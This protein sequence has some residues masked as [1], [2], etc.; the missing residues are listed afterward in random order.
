[1]IKIVH[2]LLFFLL[3][4]SYNCAY[5]DD[6]IP[7]DEIPVLTLT[8]P[9]NILEEVNCFVIQGN[10]S[11]DRILSSDISISLTLTNYSSVVV[12][13]TVE[14]PFGLTSSL[15]NMP[16]FYSHSEINGETNYSIEIFA[17]YKEFAFDKKDI[18]FSASDLPSPNEI[19]ALI[20]LY[21]CT[22]GE[23]WFD[24]SG[25]LGNPGIEWYG[26]WYGDILLNSI[27]YMQFVES[28]DL[29]D[30]IKIRCC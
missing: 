4:V 27:P 30:N 16:V 3:F 9:E 23:D 6:Q 19:S 11:I 8:L 18:Q 2:Y 28:I 26:L 17:S 13:S 14:I 22:G 25:W 15:F 12:E 1:M 5:S 21:E 20:K 7:Q 10:V 29:S 24:N